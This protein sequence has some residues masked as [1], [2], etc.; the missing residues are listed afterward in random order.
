M[1]QKFARA[2]RM[3]IAN[4]AVVHHE[5]IIAFADEVFGKLAPAFDALG[6]SFQVKNHAPG[7]GYFEKKAVDVAVVFHVEMQFFKRERVFVLKRLREDFGTEEKE[8]LHE[9]KNHA[10]GNI[11]NANDAQESGPIHNKRRFCKG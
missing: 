9:I 8:V 2:R 10:E 6:V 5:K 11:G 3:A 7:V 1:V 4:A